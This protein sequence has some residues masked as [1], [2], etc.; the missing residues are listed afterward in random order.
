MDAFPT[1]KS[2]YIYIRKNAPI[3]DVLSV[4][5]YMYEKVV[6]FIVGSALV[7]LKQCSVTP[8][9]KVGLCPGI[10]VSALATKS[11]KFVGRILILRVFYPLSEYH[12]IVLRS[13]LDVQATLFS[14][15]PCV[16]CVN[17]SRGL[18]GRGLSRKVDGPERIV[19]AP[20]CHG[21]RSAS[22]VCALASFSRPVES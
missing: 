4:L 14:C 2:M 8:H 12:G 9:R 20:R 10:R 18:P 17:D 11:L 22:H 1:H 21:A 16:C 7:L 6:V 3:R 5:I 19:R 15:G 13:H